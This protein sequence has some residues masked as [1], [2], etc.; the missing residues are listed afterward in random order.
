MYFYSKAMMENRVMYIL[1]G[2]AA[3]EIYYG[4]VDTGAISDLKR[5]FDIVHRFVDDYCSY[6]FGQ[7]IFD[8]CVSN[9]ALDRR[10]SRVASEMD[11][12]YTKTKQLLIENKPKLDN[13]IARL[14]AEKTLLGDQ[15]QEATV[16]ITEGGLLPPR[17]ELKKTLVAAARPAG[18]GAKP[19]KLAKNWGQRRPRPA[20]RP[21]R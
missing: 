11:R 16:A 21:S 5:A 18:G 12:F 7:F 19:A 3:T 8:S 13:L 1:A 9:E 6:G 17:L 20:T 14:V 2:K 15:V 10:D 4:T